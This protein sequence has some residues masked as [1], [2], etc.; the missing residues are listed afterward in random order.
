MQLFPSFIIGAFQLLKCSAH[1]FFL[2]IWKLLATQLQITGSKDILSPFLL[3][4][5]EGRF[6]FLCSRQEL[7]V[8]ILVAIQHLGFP[9]NSTNCFL[10]KG[11]NCLVIV[12]NTVPQSMANRVKTISLKSVIMLPSRESQNK[13]PEICQLIMPT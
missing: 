8:A 1:F 2:A 7:Y 6:I 3:R 12:I 10:I 13:H 4:E 11:L 9:Q 5:E